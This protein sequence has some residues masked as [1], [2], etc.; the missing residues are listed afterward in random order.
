MSLRDV[1][2]VSRRCRSGVETLE[3]AE[4]IIGKVGK[5]QKERGVMVWVISVNVA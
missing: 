4:D 5:K 1:G 3:M 2:N